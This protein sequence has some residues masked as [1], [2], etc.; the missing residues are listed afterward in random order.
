MARTIN[1]IHRE[2]KGWSWDWE[3]SLQI[4]GPTGGSTIL[5]TLLT[6]VE[7]G[8]WYP[9]LRRVMGTEHL[10]HIRCYSETGWEDPL[11]GRHWCDVDPAAWAA[12]CVRRLSDERLRYNGLRPID[13]PY[14]VVSFANEQDLAVEGHAGAATWEHPTLDAA[15]YNAIWQWGY[16]VNGYFRDM[17]PDAKCLIGSNPLAVGH[18][19][20]DCPPDFE[21]QM[22]WA[23]AY[24][25][26]CD[27]IMLHAY[28]NADGTGT[29]ED[30]GGYWVGIRC[31]RPAGYREAV[32]G[33]PPV[34]GIP[35]PG[36]V[37]VQYPDKPF[38]VSEFGNFRHDDASGLGVTTTL[39]GYRECYQAYS[40]SGRCALVTPFLWNSADEH[41]QNRIRG[42]TLLTNGLI[43]LQRYAACDWPPVVPP[44]VPEEEETVSTFRVGNLDVID[45]RAT[46]P[47]GAVSYE[48]RSIGNI[49]QIVIHHSA[50]PDDRSAEA[51]A[52]YHVD[53]MEWPGI[54]YHFL[55]HQDGRIEYTQPIEIISYGVARRNDN[56][57]HICLVGDWTATAPGD[58][59]LRAARLLIDNLDFAL[60]RVYPVVGHGEIALPGYETACPG[61]TWPT[62]KR[63]LTEAGQPA[64]DWQARAEAAEGRVLELKGIIEQ[65]RGILSI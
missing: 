8:W 63:W 45:L 27:V 20:R 16:A 39:Q 54:A 59:Q 43:A 47:H 50:T 56:T 2:N 14:V 33:Y 6:D 44:V 36:G 5:D 60:G 62:W 4:T 3:R 40:D 18:D 30:N 41:K 38:I 64:I 7:N 55:V 35:D 26:T 42:N 10:I 37:A 46:L 1:G 34:G 52:R 25:A 32:Q 21:Y 28:F 53:T 57:M 15:T 49:E 9:Q 65:A 29:R 24:L 58:V 11:Y 23:E 31:L 48:G 19:L 12:E 17:A 51:I 61:A 22:A 13:D